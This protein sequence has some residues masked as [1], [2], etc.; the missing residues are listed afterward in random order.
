MGIEQLADRPPHRLSLGQKKRAALA[1]VVAMKPKVILLDEP[2]AG[3]DPAGV[4]A[5]LAILD[6][7]QRGGTQITFATHDVDLAYGWADR[8]AVLCSGRIV[9]SGPPDEVFRCRDLLDTAKLRAPWIVEVSDALLATGAWPKGEPLPR[10]PDAF[11][12]R[13]E[14]LRGP[15]GNTQLD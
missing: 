15:I 14:T 5:L 8:V 3:L 1:G 4:E 2:T 13:L 10:S 7:L 11:L 6:G 12:K 9:A